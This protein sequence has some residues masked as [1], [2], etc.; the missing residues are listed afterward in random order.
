M[1]N[2]AGYRQGDSAF[3]VGETP[4][5]K[6]DLDRPR[7]TAAEPCQAKPKWTLLKNDESY[8]NV[9]G[10]SG[11]NSK[12][13]RI[14]ESDFY[15]NGAGIVPN[16]LDSEG[17]R[18]QRL[19][20][21]RKEQRVLEQLQLLPLRLV[22]QHGL[23]RPRPAGGTDGQLP[24]RGRDRRSTAA[25]TTWSARTTSSAT[26]SGASPPSRDRAKSSS[27]TSATKPRTSTTRSSKTRWAA[28]APTPTANSTSGT[29]PAAAA[30]AG[31]GNSA[32]S[33]FAPGNGTVPL[34]TIYPACP[35][36]TVLADQVS[37]LNLT[38]GAAGQ[39]ANKATRKPSSA[40]PA[41]TRRRTSSAPGCGGSPSHPAFEK[42]TPVEIAPLPGE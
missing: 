7:Q 41:P 14:V 37:S 27:P 19:E 24:D 12:Y 40:T 16:T 42:F 18:A 8:E 17:V 10:Y 11:T 38:R 15:N 3:Y 29:T 4:C 36:P 22:V 21:V 13:V 39:L 34:S 31:R 20:R 23:R 28:T 30:T 25:P 26:T 1:I 35:Q 6:T 9:L 5:D 32:N 33:T 2:S